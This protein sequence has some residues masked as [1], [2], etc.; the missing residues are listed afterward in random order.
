MQRIAIITPS[1]SGHGGEETVI[2]EILTSKKISSYNI[3]LIIL[4]KVE[5]KEWLK[6]IFPKTR[7]SNVNNELVNFIKLSHILKPKKYNAVICL[8]RKSILYSYLI[9]KIFNLNFKIISWIHFDLTKVNR[10]FLSLADYHLAISDGIAKQFVNFGIAD[11]E[12]VI[13]IYNPVRRQK[14]VLRPHKNVII[15]VGRVTFKGQK[16][17]KE[18]FDNL[19]YLRP[20]NWSLKIIGDG[21]DKYICKKYLKETYPEM[22]NSIF[23][24]GW[25]SDPWDYVNEADV[26]VMTS[27]YEG[28][29]MVLLEAISRGIPCLSS[30]I[31]G[32]R[33][34]IKEGVNG[35]LYALGNKKQ[36]AEKIS[37][38]LNGSY[39]P[40]QVEKSI[41]KFY[42]ENYMENLL[43]ILKRIIN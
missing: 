18:L 32:P 5:S 28:L 20:Y 42:I 2:R 29:G 11:P 21:K 1:L 10:R 26:L 22:V 31:D 43:K 33:S 40:K 3:G 27:S 17:L 41:S 13:K 36:F 24:Y 25:K 37:L 8:S 39:D 38:I 19:S 6:G 30:D 4:G 14:L 16:N 9:R 23:W 12:K 35:E 34:I 15:Y 7:I